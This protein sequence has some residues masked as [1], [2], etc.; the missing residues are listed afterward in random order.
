MKPTGSP[1]D[2]SE[3]FAQALSIRLVDMLNSQWLFEA[4]TPVSELE[5]GRELAPTLIVQTTLQYLGEEA[6]ADVQFIDKKSGDLL[7]R[8]TLSTEFKA[9]RPLGADA[10]KVFD[11]FTLSIVDLLEEHSTREGDKRLGG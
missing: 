6:R 7:G 2:F 8:Y 4:V 9:Q 10:K 5:T 3:E 1:S 11:R